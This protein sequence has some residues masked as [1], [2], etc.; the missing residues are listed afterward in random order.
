M[1]L[2]SFVLT[3][4]NT[5]AI[6][7]FAEPHKSAQLT[8]ISNTV[9][10][11]FGITLALFEKVESEIFNPLQERLTA[12]T[13]TSG[14]FA[15]LDGD[16]VVLR[17]HEAAKASIVPTRAAIERGQRRAKR[18]RQISIALGLTLT[19][20]STRW[21]VQPLRECFRVLFRTSLDLA[22]QLNVR[23]LYDDSRRDFWDLFYSIR[24]QV[25]G[26]NVWIRLRLRRLDNRIKR[27]Q[28]VVTQELQSETH[29]RMKRLPVQHLPGVAD[30]M[31]WLD[32]HG[33]THEERSIVATV[34]MTL[35]GYSMPPLLCTTMALLV[36]LVTPSVAK[37]HVVLSLV[38][39]A[40]VFYLQKPTDALYIASGLYNGIAGTVSLLEMSTVHLRQH[41]IRTSS[42][43][44]MAALAASVLFTVGLLFNKAEQ[45][46]STALAVPLLSMAAALQTNEEADWANWLY[47]KLIPVAMLSALIS[48]SSIAIGKNGE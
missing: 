36:T 16:G 3:C 35:S 17:L 33:F 44:A 15:G 42:E 4:F 23:E 31:Y 41:P 13:S 25:I 37:A 12:W 10:G 9:L 43:R 24:Q 5:Y 14:P 47:G 18:F 26:A 27:V 22:D 45:T 8:A 20:A 30:T 46:I 11:S 34:C 40:A 2:V 29:W 7:Y 32:R 6:L 38:A 48:N 1:T 21:F 28:T 39:T 19:S